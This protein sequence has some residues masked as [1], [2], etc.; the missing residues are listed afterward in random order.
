MRRGTFFA[1]IALLAAAPLLAQQ[2]A[3]PAPAPADPRIVVGPPKSEPLMDRGL[4]TRTEQ[5]AALLRCP[6][7]QGLSVADSPS[8]MAL[9]MKVQ[10][11]DM[12]AAG[13]DQ[14][15]ILAYFEHSYGEFVLLRPPLRGVNWLVWLAPLLALVGGATAVTW[16]LR[17]TP[18]AAKVEAP[19][20]SSPPAS[21]DLPGPDTLPDDPKL[22]SYV[23]EVRELAYG[24]PSHAGGSRRQESRVPKLRGG[25]SNG[26]H[27]R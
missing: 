27:G 2:P 1:G 18:P 5:V 12:L 17:R 22:A 14:E 4:D 21:L 20:P 15:Q 7:C 6:V 26:N 16:V 23:L 11:K 25:P 9:K 3:G 19:E 13:Y 24:R 8:D 10:V